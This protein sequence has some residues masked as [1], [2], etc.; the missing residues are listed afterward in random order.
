[1]K[2]VIDKDKDIRTGRVYNIDS[3]ENL[4]NSQKHIFKKTM[5]ENRNTDVSPKILRENQCQEEFYNN[6]INESLVKIEENVQIENKCDNK[7]RVDESIIENISE[8][9]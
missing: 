7:I 8:N 1:M 5:S 4:E 2:D 3:H 6:K 9:V